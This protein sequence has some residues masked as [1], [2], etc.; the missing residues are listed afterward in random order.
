VSVASAF[1]HQAN[2]C[3]NLGSPFMDQLCTLFATRD[4]PEGR[5]KT[6]VHGWNGDIGPSGH[7]VPLRL[8][9][10][11]HALK[12]QGHEGLTAVYPPNCVDDDTL[13]TAIG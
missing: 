8:C 13:W 5:I 11:L 12:L 1:A 3:A 7:S 6:R 9:G 2:A 4:W 10:G